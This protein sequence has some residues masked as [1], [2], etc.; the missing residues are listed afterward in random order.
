MIPRFIAAPEIK[1]GRLQQVLP[2]FQ[3]RALPVFALWP[4]VAP[5]PARTR[6]LVDHLITE[7]AD[8]KPWATDG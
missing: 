4:P 3:T 2:E 1:A 8:G 6:A 5:M 7:L